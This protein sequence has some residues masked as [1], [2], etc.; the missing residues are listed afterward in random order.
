MCVK[1]VEDVT[2]DMKV[3]RIL[4]GLVQEVCRLDKLRPQG[5]EQHIGNL[6]RVDADSCYLDLRAII[7]M[8]SGNLTLPRKNLSPYTVCFILPL[9]SV[10]NLKYVLTPRC[11]LNL[12]GRKQYFL[13]MEYVLTPRCQLNL[14]GREEYFLQME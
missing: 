11:Q 14:S 1:A 8:F 2:T 10:F 4:G 6:K 7:D 3:E 13:Q 5:V 9:N 12:S